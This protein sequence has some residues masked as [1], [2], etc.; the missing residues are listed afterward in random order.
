MAGLPGGSALADG[1][2][3]LLGGLQ[4][5]VCGAALGAHQLGQLPEALPHPA[6]PSL[7][8]HNGGVFQ[9]VG[10]GGGDF[11]ELA[12]I[13]HGGVV[14]VH[15][16][17]LH[18]VQHRHRV[19]GLQAV[20]H[21]EQHGEQI[22]VLAHIEVVGEEAGHHVGHAPVVNE[23]GAQH[24]L[25]GHDGVGKLEIAQFVCGHSGASS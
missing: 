2:N 18:S 4:E 17:L 22:P 5:L 15:P 9:H 8:R 3:A 20:E 19:D 6:Q 21:G 16:G 12:Q 13:G 10:G 11:H 14:V 7:V 24:R 25:L 1:V 23:H